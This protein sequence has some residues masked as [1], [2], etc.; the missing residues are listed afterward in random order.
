MRYEDNFKVNLKQMFWFGWS[1]FMDGGRDRY[2]LR[3]EVFEVLNPMGARF[4]APVKI[5]LEVLP[6]SCTT[7][8][9]AL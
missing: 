2:L 4:S 5:E 9:G 6:A 3:A 7:G 1:I 8:I